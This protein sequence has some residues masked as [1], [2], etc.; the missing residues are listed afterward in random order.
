MTREADLIN[1]LKD[2]KTELAGIRMELEN[3]RESNIELAEEAVEK[4]PTFW[5]RGY[6]PKS[7]VTIFRCTNCNY[8]IS[9][10]GKKTAPNKSEC[11]KCNAIMSGV[12]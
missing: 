4:T 7:D 12:I 6:Y 1:I 9:F 8:Q 11:P 10:N 3:L 5:F 2:I